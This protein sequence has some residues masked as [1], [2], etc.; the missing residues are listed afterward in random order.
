MSILQKSIIILCFAV[1]M[2]VSRVHFHF[3]VDYRREGSAERH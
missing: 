2:E 3:P 1:I